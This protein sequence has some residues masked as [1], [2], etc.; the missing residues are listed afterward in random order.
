M[1]PAFQSTA[2]LLTLFDEH[3]QNARAAIAA[4]SDEAFGVP[5]TL[6][7]DGVQV[8]TLPRVVVLRSFVMNHIIHHRGQY[9]VYLRLQDVPLPS[10]YG[11]TADTAG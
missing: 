8:F 7:D 3:M 9:T 1:L 5:W 2:T 11:P 10:S 6:K 4:A